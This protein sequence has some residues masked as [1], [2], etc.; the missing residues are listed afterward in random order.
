MICSWTFFNWRNLTTA[1]WFLCCWLLCGC[2]WGIFLCSTFGCCCCFLCGGFCCCQSFCRC[3][4]SGCCACGRHLFR[5]SLHWWW[6]CFYIICL[7][8]TEVCP[9]LQ[10]GTV[11][12][13]AGIHRPDLQ[14]IRKSVNSSSHTWSHSC[15]SS[16]FIMS[17]LRIWLSPYM[18]LPSHPASVQVPFWKVTPSSVGWPLKPIKLKAEGRPRTLARDSVFRLSDNIFKDD[19]Q[20]YCP[21]HGPFVIPEPATRQKIHPGVPPCCLQDDTVPA[22]LARGEAG[23]LRHEPGARIKEAERRLLSYKSRAHKHLTL[24]QSYLQ[25]RFSPE[26]II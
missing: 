6:F 4:L 22:H 23:H 11:A 16:V 25:R 13:S 9:D 19:S 8:F 7:F 10:T 21:T 18:V 17:R 15:S 1:G 24:F 5:R 20:I 12:E 26:I 14:R 3:W 2:C